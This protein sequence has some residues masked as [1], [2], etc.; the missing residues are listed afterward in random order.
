MLLVHFPPL[1]RDFSRAVEE[2]ILIWLTFRTNYLAISIAYIRLVGFIL[3]ALLLFGM[4][5]FEGVVFIVEDMYS[6]SL[7]AF[8]GMIWRNVFVALNG[9]D[10]LSILFEMFV[11]MGLAIALIIR[12]AVA[13]A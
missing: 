11:A 5:P 8:F 6:R 9:A 10:A 2:A 1:G 13:L 3:L 12:I 7:R 4:L